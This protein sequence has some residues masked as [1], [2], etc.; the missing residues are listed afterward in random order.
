[1]HGSHTLSSGSHRHAAVLVHG[2]LGGVGLGLLI[3]I[4]QENDL[5]P[6]VL[7]LHHELVNNTRRVEVGRGCVCCACACCCV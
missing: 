2:M 3:H 4:Q 7:H 5:L 6:R 1:M